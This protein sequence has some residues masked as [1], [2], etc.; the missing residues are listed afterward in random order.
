M[1]IGEQNLVQNFSKSKT[2]KNTDKGSDFDFVLNSEN[3]NN[4]YE[5]NEKEYR[6]D[7]NKDS[8]KDYNNDY[9]KDYSRDKV[10][11]SKDIIEHNRNKSI[12]EKPEEPEKS[13]NTEKSEDGLAE[14]T[15]KLKEDLVNIDD[16]LAIL[17]NSELNTKATEKV[18]E[19][20]S[21]ILNISVEEIK[22]ILQ[23]LDLKLT[24]LSVNENLSSFLKTVYS[25]NENIDLLKIENIDSIMKEIE[26]LIKVNESD[27]KLENVD[28]SEL[29]KNTET[30]N[31]E[32]PLRVIENATTVKK[33]NLPTG[34]KDNINEESSEAEA[35]EVE[36]IDINKVLVKAETKENDTGSQQ[37]PMNFSNSRL[38]N[39]NIGQLSNDSVEGFNFQEN[40]QKVQ[41]IEIKEITAP[42]FRNLDQKDIV[43]QML[44]SMKA[45]FSAEGTNEMKMLLKPANLGEV[46]LK[47]ATDNGIV[48]A[49][50]VAESTKIK[51]I[52]EANFNLLRDA[53][54]EQ[55]V[56]ISSLEV[57]VREESNF[58][59]SNEYGENG[60]NKSGSNTTDDMAVEEEK[61][62][63]ENLQNDSTVSYKA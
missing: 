47:I 41:N 4:S 21:D 49:Q 54:E 15:E 45:E 28:F 10:K 18:L 52:I 59:S 23:S 6:K 26:N 55:G 8:S 1:I 60:E 62:E 12:N 39:L 3:K 58:N 56:N 11:D 30:S 24:D 42:A 34:I 50:F 35:K 33:D 48:T 57:S 20:L 5:K 37:G 29:K 27:L 32:M 31:V 19:E 46:A 14:K 43:S 7:Y 51:E 16:L 13:K 22:S 53:L 44:N 61:V 63:E 17:N 36:E 9:N 2:N 25:V 38:G 40:L